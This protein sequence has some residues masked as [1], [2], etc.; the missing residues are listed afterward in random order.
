LRSSGWYYANWL[1]KLRAF[2]DLLAGCI[3]TRRG[4]KN[5]IDFAVGETVDW[6]RVEV[7]EKNRRVRFKGEF[8]LPGRA[9]LEFEVEPEDKGAI[10]RQTVGFDPKGVLGLVYWYGLLPIHGVMFE[11]MLNKIVQKA[12]EEYDQRVN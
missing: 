1:W 12:E 7:Y 4:R 2:I 9:W 5:P 8:K 3:G 10:I 6:W 11:G